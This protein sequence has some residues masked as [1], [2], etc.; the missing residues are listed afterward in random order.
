TYTFVPTTGQCATTSSATLTITPIVTPSGEANPLVAA[1]STLNDLVITP[2]NVLW[3]ASLQDAQSGNNSLPLSTLLSDGATYYAVA[4]NSGC[5]SMPFAVTVS[6]SLGVASSLFSGFSF[7][8]NPVT[9]LVTVANST[10]LE[11]LEVFNSLGQKIRV[12]PIRQETA[13]LDMSGLDPGIYI[14]K[15]QVGQA[16]KTLKMLKI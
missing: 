15:V 14:V 9:S 13:V 5:R 16:E 11:Q 6:F 12:Y 3:Y 4:V 10:T 2:T 7:Q 1:G 8:P